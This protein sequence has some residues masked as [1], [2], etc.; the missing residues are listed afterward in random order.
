M[1]KQGLVIVYT[2]GGKGKTTAALGLALRAVGRGLSVSMIQFIKGSWKSGEIEASKF[3]P[4]FEIQTMG[5]GFVDKADDSAL[6]KH[7][8][9][10]LNALKTAEA[11]I[12]S[13][14]HDLVI[15]DEINCA[16]NLGLL[17]IDDVVQMVSEKPREVNLAL[18]GRNAPKELID[19]ADIATEMLELK[20][21]FTKGGQAAPGIDF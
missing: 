9:A 3:L 10:A 13:G 19:L 6:Q 1:S 17:S 8:S 12:V 4:N 18:T 7:K 21:V 15:L 2:G 5:L 20:H 11:A 16:I 14:I